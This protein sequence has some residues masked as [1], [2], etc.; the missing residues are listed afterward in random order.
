MQAPFSAASLEEPFSSGEGSL[1]Q[2]LSRGDPEE[3]MVQSLDLQAA[4]EG[5]EP[6][7]RAVIAL[8]F[9]RGL[10][11]REAARALGVTQ[12]HVSRLEKRALAALK[13]KLQ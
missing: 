7:L 12:A 11:Q 13:E 2:V 8:R 6:R 1:A 5:L 3:T 9:G 10:T 4:L